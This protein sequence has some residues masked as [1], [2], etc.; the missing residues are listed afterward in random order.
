MTFKNL[1]TLMFCRFLGNHKPQRSNF[2]AR[3]RT[4]VISP[5]I[6]KKTFAFLSVA[7]LLRLSISF[8][9][10][11]VLWFNIPVNNFSHAGTEP[12]F[13]WY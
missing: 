1:V 2:H 11:V 13:P 9:Q 4:I 3:Q 7:K 6:D 8:S 12:P 5:I 10:R